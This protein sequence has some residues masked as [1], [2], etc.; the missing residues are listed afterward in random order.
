MTVTPIPWE[1]SRFFV[2]SESRSGVD[3]VVD[4]AYV[5]EGHKKSHAACGCESNF[6]Y[7]RLCAH[8]RAAVNAERERLGL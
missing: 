1:K 7:G 4:L 3:H 8:I 2:S 6:I 5:E